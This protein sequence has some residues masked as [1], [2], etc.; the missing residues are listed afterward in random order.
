MCWSSPVFLFFVEALLW[1]LIKAGCDLSSNGYKLFGPECKYMCHCVSNSQCNDSTGECMVGCDPG[2]TGPGCQYVDIAYGAYVV[3]KTDPSTLTPM[4]L[5]QDGDKLHC[6]IYSGLGRPSISFTFDGPVEISII[7]IYYD[8]SKLFSPYK[9]YIKNGAAPAKLCYEKITATSNS[10]SEFIVKVESIQCPQP[11]IGDYIEIFNN[12][13]NVEF[14]LCEIDIPIGRNVAF[15]RKVYQS[16]N[17]QNGNAF[18]AVD[19]NVEGATHQLSCSQTSTAG[20]S[21]PWWYIELQ[22]TWRLKNVL[23]YSPGADLS[24]YRTMMA[25]FQV[26]ASKSHSQYNMTLL[27]DNGGKPVKYITYISGLPFTDF[28]YVMISIPGDNRIISLCEVQVLSDCPEKSCGLLCNIPCNC[29]SYT[30][31]GQLSGICNGCEAGW[32]GSSA[33]MCDIPCSSGYYG[34]NCSTPCGHCYDH[35]ACDIYTGHCPGICESGYSGQKCDIGKE[36]EREN[37]LLQ[38]CNTNCLSK[39]NPQDVIGYSIISRDNFTAAVYYSWE[40]YSCNTSDPQ[41]C[42]KD[43]KNCCKYGP[44]E[45][46]R[47]FTYSNLTGGMYYLL[48]VRVNIDL[49]SNYEVLSDS[50]YATN[51][52]LA[53]DCSITPSAGYSFLTVFT[54]RCQG[55]YDRDDN[56]LMYNLYYRNPLCFKD[57]L[58]RPNMTANESKITL[59][60]PGDDPYLSLIVRVVDPYGASV[61][62][63]MLVQEP[64]TE[65]HSGEEIS[66]EQARENITDRLLPKTITKC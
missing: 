53:G 64:E 50:F 28:L 41:T 17:Q 31:F 34:E 21:N 12:G 56:V 18:K 36:I 19:G 35:V 39:R 20:T 23:V 58:M 30:F 29:K 45:I 32:T 7:Q 55:F 48:N 16:S 4:D 62:V 8:A 15:G 61:D 42:T 11:M 1:Y 3:M 49:A 44:E 51:I 25:H 13:S 46:Q 5:L 47:M 22:E 63:S 37:K 10:T 54:I 66:A 52:P 9:L 57:I 60:N 27:Y 65:N 59:Y 40:L 2:W 24:T 33:E 6:N 38:K 43:K 26:S 14:P